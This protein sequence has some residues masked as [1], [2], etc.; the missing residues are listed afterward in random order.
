[1]FASSTATITEWERGAGMRCLADLSEAD[2]SK[3][4]GPQRLGI[5]FS[6][7]DALV[8]PCRMHASRILQL[9][10]GRN[11]HLFMVAGMGNV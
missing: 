2:G 10:F 8:V 11:L 6:L 9:V 7:C 4:W 1:M 3:L 5:Y